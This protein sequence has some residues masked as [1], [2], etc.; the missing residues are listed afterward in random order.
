MNDVIFVRVPPGMKEAVRAEADARLMTMSDVV[1]QI[2]MAY[3][4]QKEVEREHQTRVDRVAE[5]GAGT[6]DGAG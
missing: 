5:T 3:Y 4:Q 2:L 6:E 1:R